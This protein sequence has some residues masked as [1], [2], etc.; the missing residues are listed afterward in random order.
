[1]KALSITAA[2]FMLS[3][4]TIVF[5][6]AYF[7]FVT[8]RPDGSIDDRLAS[9]L[10]SGGLN[11]FALGALLALAL[12]CAQLKATLEVEFAANSERGHVTRG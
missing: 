11:T 2:L 9:V 5:C 12:L 8:I 10:F 4:V 3:G 6:S 1:M 7:D